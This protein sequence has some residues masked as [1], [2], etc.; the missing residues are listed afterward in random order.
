MLGHAMGASSAIE[1][2]L[3]IRGMQAG[4]IPPTI[5][6]LADPPLGLDSV[7]TAC[8]RVDQEYVLKNAFG[9][10]GCNACV[11]LRRGTS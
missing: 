10:G 5:N 3:A 4:I 11:V 8:R 6:Y 1:S 2:I 7:I 9:F